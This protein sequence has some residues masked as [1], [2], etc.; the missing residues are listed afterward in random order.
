[1]DFKISLL[2]KNPNIYLQKKKLSTY[3]LYKKKMT[4]IWCCGSYVPIYRNSFA[5]DNTIVLM[6]KKCILLVSMAC[7]SVLY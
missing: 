3:K 4:R 1:M 2:E 6:D 5:A 7:L